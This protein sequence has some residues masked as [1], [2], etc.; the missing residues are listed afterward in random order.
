MIEVEK[1]YQDNA[2][3]MALSNIH[4][5]RDPTRSFHTNQ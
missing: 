5:L 2:C 3:T 1:K 4:R